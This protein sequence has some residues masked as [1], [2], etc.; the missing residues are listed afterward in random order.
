MADSYEEADKPPKFKR[1]KDYDYLL[2]T[3]LDP[4]LF[5]TSW[6]V[7]QIENKYIDNCPSNII[8]SR[9][10][11]FMGWEYLPK[12]LGKCYDTIIYCD[13]TRVPTYK[14]N[15]EQL[16]EDAQ[17][18]GL[19][20]KKHI[21]NA[22]QECRRL[23]R[24]PHKDSPQRIN[25]V[26]DWFNSHDFPRGLLMPE[27]CFFAYD[28][29]NASVTSA[30]NSFWELFVTDITN[31]DQ[32]LWSYFLWKHELKPLIYS[33][34]QWRACFSLIMRKSIGFNGHRHNT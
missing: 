24:L 29:N 34:A 14:F 21:R 12:A 1:H 8:K 30:F 2:F 25:A 20:Q 26:T 23:K 32:P 22:W 7:T 5:D 10:I 33:D 15:W 17:T 31:R 9:Y 27:N 19:V 4:S 13:A 28:P 18:H 3:N 6:T 16:G 11:K